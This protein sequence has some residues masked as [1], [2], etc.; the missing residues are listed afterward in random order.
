MN[1]SILLL[2]GKPMHKKCSMPNAQTISNPKFIPIL[3]IGPYLIVC[4][5][6]EKVGEI[7]GNTIWR[8]TETKLHSYKKTMLHLTEK[9]V[10]SL[11]YN[12]LLSSPNSNGCLSG[13][14]VK[15]LPLTTET[16]VRYLALHVR[17]SPNWTGGFPLGTLVFWPTWRPP[18]RNHQCR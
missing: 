11:Y 8:A 15:C 17:W 1:F 16:W 3:T 4:T 13:P 18:K 14:A 5:K 12:V 6:K 7:R 2:Y 10:S 9:Q